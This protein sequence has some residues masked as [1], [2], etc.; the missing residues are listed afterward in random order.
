LRGCGYGAF[1]EVP[2]QVIERDGTRTWLI[3]G[4]HTVVAISEVHQGTLLSRIDNPDEYMA[5][6]DEDGSATCSAGSGETVTAGPGSVTI[7]PP[8][9]SSMTVHSGRYVVR[10]FTT[11]AEDLRLLALNNENY[12]DAAPECAP[13]IYWPEPVGGYRLRTY[14]ILKMECVTFSR[15]IRSTN[16]MVSTPPRSARRRDPRKLSPHHHDD[17]EQVSVGLSGTWVHH[18]RVPWTPD[19]T[20]WRDDEHVTFTSPSAL[21]IPAG[22]VHT[23]QDIGEEESCI[24]DVFSPPRADFSRRPGWV[25]NAADYPAPPDACA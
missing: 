22:L 15:I 21:V 9:P 13:L 10:C 20:T 19:S 3:R 8:G 24:I 1:N 6:L 5:I 14:D 4:A 7:V 12:G 16:L 11:R 2:P 18:L 25:L 23:S 17:F